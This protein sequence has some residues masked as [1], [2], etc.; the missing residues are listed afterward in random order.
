LIAVP[1]TGREAW[2]FGRLLACLARCLFTVAVTMHSGIATA[3]MPDVLEQPALLSARA[4][5]S[6]MLGIAQTGGRLIAVGER[7][8]VLVSDDSASSWRQAVVPVSTTLTAVHFTT[9][10]KGWAVGHSGTVVHTEDGGVSWIRQLDGHRA[11]RLVL[12]EAQKRSSGQAQL[13]EAQRLVDEGPDKPFLDVWFADEN[14]GFIVGAY[15]LFFVTQ[16][17]GKSWLPWHTRL[18]NPDA[19]HL[20]SIKASGATIYIAGEEGAL[21][22][23]TDGGTSFTRVPTPYHGSYF[24]VLP[25]DT[26]RVLVFG[27]RGNAYLSDNAGNHWRR[28]AT[29]T[30]A[31]LTAGRLLRDGSI[32]LTSQA[33]EVLRSTD[34]GRSFH[35]LP[36]KQPQPFSGIAE[37]AGRGLVLTGNRGTVR[38]QLP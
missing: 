7:G 10:K 23:S 9:G 20:Y 4:S 3:A 8:I 17:G 13:A 33:G 5:A 19:R 34:Q 37:T 32:V 12:E 2:R 26:E 6:V 16:D 35:A 38:V 30:E 18:D 24:G 11:A 28:L 15:G 36:V 1:T 14:R 27:L 21:F 25:L 29:G 31:A 22:R